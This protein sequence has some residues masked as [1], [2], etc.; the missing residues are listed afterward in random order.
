M[1]LFRYILLSSILL[2]AMTWTAQAQG[3]I[4]TIDLR[5]VF[6]KYHKTVAA[7]AALKEEAAELDLD[8]KK[9]LEGFRKEE[10]EWR[11]LLD[12]SNDQALSAE[13]RERSKRTA[14][15]KLVGLRE[16]EQTITGF[17]RSARAQLAEKQRR[18]RDAIL[19]E[20]RD[21][22]NARA[23]AAGYSLV[24]DT[25]AESLANTPVVIFSTGENDMTEIVLN[26]LNSSAPGSVLRPEEPRRQAPARR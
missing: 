8:K 20:I 22:I 13:E 19:Q 23:K 6:D 16:R 2:T 26:Q 5:V 10:E 21:V 15:Q 4:G 7:D 25:A 12:R 11:A 17:E 24:L 3:K 14:E 18:K 1:K 9:M